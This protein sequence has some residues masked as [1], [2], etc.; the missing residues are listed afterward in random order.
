VHEAESRALAVAARREML[1]FDASHLV[2]LLVGRVVRHLVD[3]GLLAHVTRLEN[4]ADFAGHKVRI[5]LFVQER[6]FLC[7][8]AYG[9]FIVQ[10]RNSIIPSESRSQH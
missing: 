5:R 7:R 2:L 1:A 10:S 3:A 6:E 8:G 4:V 9:S